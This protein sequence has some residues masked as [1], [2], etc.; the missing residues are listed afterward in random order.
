MA[1]PSQATVKVQEAVKAVQDFIRT[2]YG[3]DQLR[4]VEL[5]EIELLDSPPEWQ[6][7]MGF[8]S[9]A[10]TFMTGG[11]KDLRVF[12]VDSTSGEVKS[13]KLRK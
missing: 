9:P 5:E 3:P 1:S 4:Y 7:T 8:S 13:M 2:L 10:L 6:I 12:R 11:K